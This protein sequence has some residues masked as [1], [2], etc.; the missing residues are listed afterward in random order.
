MPH[1]SQETQVRMTEGHQWPFTKRNAIAQ[2]IQPP[3]AF[4]KD[5][6]VKMRS[7]AWFRRNLKHKSGI[8]LRQKEYDECLTNCP[9]MTEEDKKEIRV[10]YQLCTKEKFYFAGKQIA[11]RLTQNPMY[12]DQDTFASSKYNQHW[13][14]CIDESNR[15]LDLMNQQEIFQ[16]L[17]ST[18]SPLDWPVFYKT[19]DYVQKCL[20][21]T[22]VKWHGAK[23]QRV[24]RKE[25]R[26]FYG[27]GNIEVRTLLYQ[28]YVERLNKVVRIEMNENCTEKD[29]VNPYHMKRVDKKYRLL[30][31]VIP[32]TSKRLIQIQDEYIKSKNCSKKPQHQYNLCVSGTMPETT[33]EIKRVC[34][35]DEP[36]EKRRRL[37]PAVASLCSACNVLVDNDTCGCWG[38]D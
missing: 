4:F 22:C 6:V 30:E 17:L 12:F 33:L 3:K 31:P 29:C 16:I 14:E 13:F 25:Q 2:M 32:M 21:D 19:K 5:D 7:T 23:N 35:E 20:K 34:V 15:L 38:F 27:R 18:I 11:E 37:E 24:K 28:H 1:L 10:L 36:A 8:D 26:F 9:C